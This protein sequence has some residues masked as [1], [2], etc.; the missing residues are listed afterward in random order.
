MAAEL[1]LCPQKKRVD[2][3]FLAPAGH[4]LPREKLFRS[5]QGGRDSSYGG[6]SI[7]LVLRQYNFV[8]SG[9]CQ[10][11]YLPAGSVYPVIR[12]LIWA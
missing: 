4:L 3:I 9:A 5:I 12:H 10:Q 8:L 2:S 6:K 1:S 11:R 7:S